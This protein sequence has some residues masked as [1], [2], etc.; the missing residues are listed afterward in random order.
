MALVK[1]SAAPIFEVP[2][3]LI[4]GLT[5]PKRGASEVSTWHIEIKPG[6]QSEEHW[7]DHEETF[8]VV[9][10][11]LTA[12]VNKEKIEVSSGDALAVPAKTPMQLNNF[13]TSPVKAVACVPC[14]TQGTMADGR[15]IGVPPWAQ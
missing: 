10:G 8:I 12:Y 7:L 14:G 11:T 5:S 13:G 4:T 9:E 1:T 6:G 15:E 2:G 3:F